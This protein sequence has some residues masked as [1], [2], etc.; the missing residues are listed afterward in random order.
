M[1]TGLIV[2]VLAAVLL[3]KL[4]GFAFR[5]FGKLF[6]F[7]LS[8]AAATFFGVIGLS[9]I[10]FIAVPIALITGVISILTAI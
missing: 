3:I 4:T 10:G 2:T 8:C 7:A 1:I 6:G 9:L 5:L